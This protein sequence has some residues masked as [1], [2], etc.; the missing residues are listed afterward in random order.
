MVS[1]NG[2]KICHSITAPLG[3]DG[4]CRLC[5]DAKVASDAGTTYGKFKARLY[6]RYGYIPEEQQPSYNPFRTCPN[7]GK[8]FV[9]KRSNVIYC[10]AACGTQASRK[11]CQKKGDKN[12]E[13]KESD[14]A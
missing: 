10:G 12:G 8:R 14:E 3:A 2:C 5:R 13:P 4:R 11:R 7:C 6:E 9:P 1:S